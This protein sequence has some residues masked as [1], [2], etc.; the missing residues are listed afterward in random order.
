MRRRDFV[1]ALAADGDICRNIQQ[2]IQWISH[3]DTGGVPGRYEIDDTQKI[4]YGFV[5]KTIGDPGFT[6]YI[7][8]EYRPA[9]G[10]API[11]SLNQAMGIMDV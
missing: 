8:H 9:P 4:N 1:A 6:G 7:V 10:R 2:N 5:A 3:F 11:E